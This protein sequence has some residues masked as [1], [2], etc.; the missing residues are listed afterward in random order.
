MN[1]DKGGLP[2][3]FRAKKSD[4]PERPRIGESQANPESRVAGHLERM[5]QEASRYGF[6]LRNLNRL[7]IGESHANPES[8]VAGHLERMPKKEASRY[9]FVL[10]NQTNLKPATDRRILGES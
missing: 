4:K 6:V 1:P 9:G 7:R 2:V 3:W 5:P 8:R 10:R